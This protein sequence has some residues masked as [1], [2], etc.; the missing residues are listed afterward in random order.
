MTFWICLATVF[1]EHLVQIIVMIVLLGCSAF[2]SGSETAFFH[3]SRKTVRQFS[4][5]NLPLEQLVFKILNDPNRFLTA[6]LFGNMTVN[7]LFFSISSTLL[8]NVSQTYGPFAATATGALC[9]FC[10]LLFGE[11]LPKSVAFVNTKRFCLIASPACYFLLSFLRPVLIVL[12]MLFV[13][14]TI[15]LV[16]PSQQKNTISMK[17][18]NILL[19]SS[20]RQGLINN[21]ESQLLTE[22]LKFSHLKVRH[23]MLPRVEMAACSLKRSPKDI[24]QILLEKRISK[25]PV[26]TTDVDHIVGMIQLRD[27]L[28]DPEKTAESM[29][30]PVFFVPEQ[31]TVESLLD[32]FKQ[33]HTDH[34]VVVDEYGGVA[35]F[36]DIDNITE[37]LLGPMEDSFEGEPIEQIGP[38]Q[39]RLHANLSIS[40]WGDAF[41]VEI[42]E[43]RLTTIGGFVTALLEKIPQPGDSVTF[44]K[45]RFTV[46]NAHN[47][48]IHTILLSVEPLVNLDQEP[49]A[50]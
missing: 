13:Q 43:G 28:L 5:S 21:D 25:I 31:K 9:F 44:G 16:V 10:L 34:A 27:I 46:E 15:K 45:M 47:N 24:Q 50:Q 32:F 23:V 2:F 39:Y 11:M 26:Y 12:D 17:Q 49:N 37:Q 33:S 4:H 14:T 40:D 35:G 7:V 18:L 36:V 8:L 41:G 6:L 1:I 38:F 48:R 3:L 29:M 30:H 20:R 19:D 42:T 22:I